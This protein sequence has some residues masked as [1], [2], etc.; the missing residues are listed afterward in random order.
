MAFNGEIQA[1]NVNDAVEVFQSFLLEHAGVHVILK[2]AVVYLL[3]ISS[4]SPVS[5]SVTYRQ[6]DAVQA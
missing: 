1:H 3:S 4:C 2:V 6:P 5:V